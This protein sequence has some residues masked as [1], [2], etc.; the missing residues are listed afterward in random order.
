MTGELH[1]P[2]YERTGTWCKLSRPLRIEYE[3]EVYHVTSRGNER[4]MGS[5]ASLATK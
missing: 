5:T 1:Q 4:E 3:G 2:K